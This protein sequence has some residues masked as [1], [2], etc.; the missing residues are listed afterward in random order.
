[1]KFLVAIFLFFLVVKV[2]SLTTEEVFSWWDDGLIENTDVTDFLELLESGNDEEAIELAISLGLLEKKSPTRKKKESFQGNV[3]GRVSLDSLGNLVTHR[4][5][6]RLAFLPWSFRGNNF[7]E[8]VLGYKRGG[9][10]VIGG[11]LKNQ[12]IQFTLPVKGLKGTWVGYRGNLFSLGG[13][14]GVKKN[15]ALMGAIKN[16]HLWGFVLDSLKIMALEYKEK[17]LE[18]TLW[19]SP[20]ES[21][22]LLRIKTN[23]SGGQNNTWKFKGLFYFQNASIE[24]EWLGIPLSVKQ[25]K[26]WTS[27]I[28]TIDIGLFTLSAEERFQ[29]PLDSGDGFSQIGVKWEKP[30]GMFQFLFGLVYKKDE[31]KN[32][33]SFRGNPSLNFQYFSVLSGFRYSSKYSKIHLPRMSFGFKSKKGEIPFWKLEWIFPENGFKKNYPLQFRNEA[34]FKADYITLSLHFLWHKPLRKEWSPARFGIEGKI[35]F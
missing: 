11:T 22:T 14:L 6:I 7:G 4:E 24:H 12:E 33:W 27:Q 28:Q 30:K 3:S 35:F 32:E 23:L 5:E 8:W 21:N 25:S 31:N 20:L 2:Q 16:F 10:E 29:V 17:Y 15:Y 19:I 9:Y 18:G 26:L 34:G 13:F 1:M